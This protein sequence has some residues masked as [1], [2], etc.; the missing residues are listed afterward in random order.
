[1]RAVK[2]LAEAL[3][4]RQ[5]EIEEFIKRV[6]ALPGETVEGRDGA[7]WVDGA[8]LVEP[9]LPP[10]TVTGDFAPVKVGDGQVWVMGDNRG[11]SSDSRVFG[12][13]DVDTI[14]GRAILRI[15]PPPRI[16]FL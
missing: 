1:V 11:N 4:L 13:V 15:W 2:A 10:G 8:R 12:T 7:V 9:Y 5:P 16:A 6:I 14:V 3:L